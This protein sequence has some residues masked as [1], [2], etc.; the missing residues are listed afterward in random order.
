MI[1]HSDPVTQLAFMIVVSVVAGTFLLIAV[2][3][4]RRWQQIRYGRYVH[5]LQR[6]Y[7]P[8]LA[9]ILSGA[10]SPA[11]IEILREMPMAELEVLLEPL[12]SRRKLPERSLVFFQALCL[13][14][15]LIELW[16]SR[17]ARGPRMAAPC[18]Q[19][20]AL[21]E[22]LGR[23]GMGLLLRAKS[24][25]NLGKL[26]HRPSWPLLVKA[27]DDPRAEV[28]FVAL[29]ALG[30]L[31]APE[32]F[33]L[34]RERLH[35]VAQGNSQSPPLRGLR[36]AMASFD[37]A[38]APALVP[39]LRHGD[40]NVRLQ[41]TEI[42][43]MIV[44][45]E[46]AFQPHLTLTAEL[47]SPQM[48]EL[49]LAALAIDAN[50]ET[51]ARTAEI[52]VFLA[53]PRATRALRNLLLDHQWF[54]RLRTV[55]ALAHL[56]QAAAPLHVQIR[57]CLRDSH[58]Q[59]REA[60]IQTLLSLGPEGTHHLYE[61]FLASPNHPTRE[62]IVEVIERRGVVFELVEM[63]SNGANGVDAR[64]VEQLA[65]ESARVGLSGILRSVPPE[66]RL[67]FLSRLFSSAEA[68]MRFHEGT[69]PGLESAVS[70]EHV[71]EFL[72]RVA[73]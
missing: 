45:R 40:G 54:V 12:F 73:A 63:Y 4:F 69:Q 37:L 58:W 42:L 18:S 16:H 68:K 7:R 19:S 28:Q 49:L 62:Q 3:L 23:P 17:L 5:A 33:P 8:V 11:A 64:M 32:S 60:A 27:L 20:G 59:V 15:G 1:D 48:V 53:D 14:L 44:S 47:L 25:R 51:R 61:H 39:S 67:R 65:A 29:R 21:R 34:L 9:G 66:V 26:R 36:A 24:I 70:T 31:G 52:I 6:K 38:C 50:S 43:R 13:E 46:A 2:A 71:L 35:A 72:P 57:G 55:Q 41:G 22:S 10:R 56:R 30:A